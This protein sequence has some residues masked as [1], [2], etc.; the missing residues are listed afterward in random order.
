M[1]LVIYVS[2]FNVHTQF[3]PP[4]TVGTVILHS[5]W[6]GSVMKGVTIK[7]GLLYTQQEVVVKPLWC[8]LPIR[9]QKFVVVGRSGALESLRTLTQASNTAVEFREKLLVFQLQPI[10]LQKEK[11]AFR[12]TETA[13]GKKI[14]FDTLRNFTV[15]VNCKKEVKIKGVVY[16]TRRVA[17]LLW[18]NADERR[19]PPYIL[20]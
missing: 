1:R 9:K 19:L 14:Y 6:K 16:E 2:V 13:D 4:N 12:H 20:L 10:K 15:D 3:K 11:N 7:F 5:A 8:K 17:V 18:V